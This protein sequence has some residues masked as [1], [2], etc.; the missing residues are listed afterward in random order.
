MR[1]IQ[2]SNDQMAIR[3][4]RNQVAFAP[5]HHNIAYVCG[6][7]RPNQSKTLAAHIRSQ[8][9]PNN[10]KL[11]APLC[12]T[13]RVYVCGV[14]RPNQNTSNTHTTERV[15]SNHNHIQPH[16]IRPV[17]AP[18]QKPPY[19]ECLVQIQKHIHNTL[20]IGINTSQRNWTAVHISSQRIKTSS[21]Q[22]S[23]H[24]NPIGSKPTQVNS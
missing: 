11:H 5:L 16:K 15:K 10:V 12:I 3:S 21:H 9:L 4:N 7:P 24:H 18:Q 1:T 6:A 14:L 13:I 20:R 19:V 22:H 17:V 8:Q 23:S 2:R